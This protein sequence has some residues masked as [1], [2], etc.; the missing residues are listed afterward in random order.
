M[1]GAGKKWAIGCGIGCA[2]FALVIIA[3]SVA[4]SLFVG[5]MFKGF[6]NAVQAREDLDERFGEARQFTP[7][8]DGAIPAERTEAF[9]AVRDSTADARKQLAEKFSVIPMSESEARELDS[10]SA[11][12]K[13]RSVLGII[14][15]AMGVGVEMGHFFDARNHAL[16]EQEMG[17]GEYTFLYTLF[18]YSVLGHGSADGPASDRD[19]DDR[20]DIEFGQ[21]SSARRIHND[22]L[23]ML[24]N[25]LRDLPDE[26]TED[27]RQGLTAEIEAME[28]DRRRYPWK[29]GVPP[30]L[31]ESIAPFHD[32][33]AAS[34]D[35]VSNP[36]ELATQTRKGWSITAE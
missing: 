7:W 11:G 34:Y 12:E 8:V 36:F 30:A 10:K 5:K 2:A 16:L 1:A 3:L 33:L 17:L 15:A 24:R 23:S 21:V 9:L 6:D 14:G 28:H 25:Q 18:Y 32:R 13:A 19:A 26:A 20:M 29:D 31:A 22:L 27:Q 4:G 35:P